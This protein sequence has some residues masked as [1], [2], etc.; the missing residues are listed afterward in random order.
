[1]TLA[2]PGSGTYCNEY[3]TNINPTTQVTLY[4]YLNSW[5]GCIGTVNFSDHASAVTVSNLGE[6]FPGGSTFYNANFVVSTIAAG[7]FTADN[8]ISNTSVSSAFGFIA[9]T[10]AQFT[11]SNGNMTSPYY[12][13]W[14]T[15]TS[16]F[17]NPLDTQIGRC[18]V[19]MLCIGDASSSAASNGKIR[20]ANVNYAGS[21]TENGA[22]NAIACA[23][24]CGPTL[25]PGLVLTIQLGHSLRAGANTF[26]Y[27]G[28]AALAIKKHLDASSNLTNAYTSSGVIQLE[29]NGSIWL[30]LSQ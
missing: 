24:G 26:A 9:G 23:A 16:V 10:E 1:M 2:N 20:V 30:D 5:Y 19:S 28:G 21:G 22:S 18:G 14:G 3:A 29:Y 7:N 8:L 13:A 27:N 12:L 11:A 4:T 6:A 17:S 25:T 15:G